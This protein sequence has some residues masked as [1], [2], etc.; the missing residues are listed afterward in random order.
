MRSPVS[1]VCGSVPTGD[2]PGAGP[3]KA[4]PGTGPTLI[5]TG[6]GRAAVQYLE[7]GRGLGSLYAVHDGVVGLGV[8]TPAETKLLLDIVF[9]LDDPNADLFGALHVFDDEAMILI[10]KAR[11]I[12]VSGSGVRLSLVHLDGLAAPAFGNRAEARI[13][14]GEF[15]T[16]G[17][18]FGGRLADG[19]IALARISVAPVVGGPPAV[20][21][22]DGALLFACGL[23]SLVWLQSGR[24]GAPRAGVA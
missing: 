1:A 9:P 23:L 21:L 12:L 10:A 7:I 17:D 20:T 13:D 11:S 22:P 15:A 14:F 24:L 18:L 5:S 6:S 3:R 16:A 8:V 2:L 4:P 19:T